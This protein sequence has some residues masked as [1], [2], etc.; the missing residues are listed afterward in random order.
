[1]GP[2]IVLCCFSAEFFL[3]LLIKTTTM[4]KIYSA[5]IALTCLVFIGKAQVVNPGIC[6]VTVDDSSKHNIVYYDKHQI[7]GV[8]SFI[9]H[10]EMVGMP[11]MYVRIMAN[12]TAAFSMFMDMDTIGGNPNHQLHRYRLQ[13]YRSAGGY[14]QLGPY[15]TALYCL[16]NA[17]NYAWNTYDIGGTGGGI[18]TKYMMLQDDNSTNAW[19]VIDS[20][21]NTTTAI[22]EPNITSFPNGQWRLAT[23]WSVS[24]NPSY[25]LSGNNTVQAAIVKSKSNISNNKQAGINLLKSAS[26]GLFPN[27]ATDQVTLRMNFPVSENTNVKIYNALGL[28]IYTSVLSFGKD[29]LI[30]PVSGF[31]KGIYFAELSNRQNKVTK[32]IVVQ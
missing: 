8:D 5:F 11:G 9:L 16:Q 31:E 13:V 19:H 30:I 32:R 25:K 24:C 20:M 17:T 15:H 29:E 14:S 2:K 3:Y 26:F 21:S 7:A 12:D 4:K 22:V 18:V 10:R 23:K 6:M 1:M 28:E 27:P